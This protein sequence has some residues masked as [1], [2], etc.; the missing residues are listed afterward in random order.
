MKISTRVELGIV[1][2]ADIA[3][4]SENGDTV[5]SSEIA[6]RQG[7]SQKYLEQIIVGLRQGGFVKGHKG[8]GGG[9]KLARPANRI[10]LSEI[11]NALDNTILADTYE[12]EEDKSNTIRSSVNNCLWD[13][14]NGYMRRF[15]EQMTLEDLIKECKGKS[16]DKDK[17]I[18]YYI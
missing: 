17:Y 7:I 16:E 14:F 5:S 9:Y 18:M 11:L 1:A 8:L 13:K 2:L 10:N 4:N 6:A 12:D 15:S 3:I